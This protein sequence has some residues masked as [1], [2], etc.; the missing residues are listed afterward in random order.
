MT[1]VVSDVELVAAIEHAY[2]VGYPRLLRVAAALLRDRDRGR[3]AVQETFARALRS[4]ADLDRIESRASTAGCGE[5]WST[6]ARIVCCC[7]SRAFQVGRGPRSQHSR[8]LAQ[9]ILLTLDSSRASRRKRRLLRY[10]PWLDNGGDGTRF[11]VANPH[12]V[13]PQL[14]IGSAI[15]SSLRMKARTPSRQPNCEPATRARSEM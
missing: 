15:W 4:R 7:R 9:A 2:R 11:S 6:S 12:G 8:T 5:P 3:D 10:R 1:A 14:R 13:A